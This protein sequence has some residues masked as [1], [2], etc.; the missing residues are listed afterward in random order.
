MSGIHRQRIYVPVFHSCLA[1]H[2]NSQPLKHK[3]QR[4]GQNLKVWIPSFSALGQ[5]KIINGANIENHTNKWSIDKSPNFEVCWFSIVRDQRLSFSHAYI[6]FKYY[7]NVSPPLPALIV[8]SVIISFP[9]KNPAFFRLLNN[10]Y[11]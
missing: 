7:M 5:L 2:I 11:V 10:L 9:V 4:T 6:T 8:C 3:Q 1:C